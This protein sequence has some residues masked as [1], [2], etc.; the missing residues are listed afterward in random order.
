MRSAS[1]SIAVLAVALAAPA[2]AQDAE[3]QCGIQEIVVTAHTREQ[4]AQ[5]WRIPISALLG[6]TR[7]RIGMRAGHAPTNAC[8]GDFD[9][10][11]T[12]DYCVNITA[13][14]GVSGTR[15]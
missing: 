11:E 3:S 9:Y 8:S 7:M 14:T 2:F 12:H 10:G 4:N 6:P 13:A 1:V 15:N 5:D